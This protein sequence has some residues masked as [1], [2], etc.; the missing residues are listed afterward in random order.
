VDQVTATIHTKFTPFQEP[1]EGSQR[2]PVPVT[3]PA[4]E[5][6]LTRDSTKGSKKIHELETSVWV[7]SDFFLRPTQGVGHWSRVETADAPQSSALLSK[8]RPAT[9]PPVVPLTVIG[10]NKIRLPTIWLGTN[11]SRSQC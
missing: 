6:E 10:K 8:P 11:T 2:Q 5:T 1:K 9:V 4:R 7:L 3:A